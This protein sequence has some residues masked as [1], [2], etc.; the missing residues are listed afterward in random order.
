MAKSQNVKSISNL[1]LAMQDR[2]AQMERVASRRTQS[3]MKQELYKKSSEGRHESPWEKEMKMVKVSSNYARDRVV[4]IAG[5][6]LILHFDSHGEAEMPEHQL[7][8]MKA[9]MR[10]RP[11]RYKLHLEEEAPAAPV[12]APVEETAV[13]MREQVASLLEV[14]EAEASESEPELVVEEDDEPVVELELESDTED[15]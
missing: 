1:V 2:E 10:V 3:K 13:V 15:E 7:D 9:E 11:G 12:V 14:L 5:G 8:L 4:M 6:K